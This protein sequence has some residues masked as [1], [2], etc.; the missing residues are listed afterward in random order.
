MNPMV[1][2]IPLAPGYLPVELVFKK[3]KGFSGA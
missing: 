3:W 2:T 1:K